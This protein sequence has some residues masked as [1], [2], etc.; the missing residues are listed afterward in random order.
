MNTELVK[1]GK[2][3]TFIGGILGIAWTSF[4]FGK[5]AG[6]TIYEKEKILLHYENTALKKSYDSLQ[7]IINDYSHK[8]DRIIEIC[9]EAEEIVKE[10][11][12][13]P[14]RIK[15]STNVVDNKFIESN[16]K[17]RA[18]KINTSSLF[19]DE[20][21]RFKYNYLGQK[22]RNGYFTTFYKINNNILY[23]SIIP[24]W[25]KSGIKGYN[26][27]VVDW[28]DIVLYKGNSINVQQAKTRLIHTEG[29]H[30]E[31]NLD[32]NATKENGEIHIPVE[33]ISKKGPA[34]NSTPT[35]YISTVKLKYNLD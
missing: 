25:S 10:D 31:F 14:I 3:V 2:I 18:T 8:N 5:E 11:S 27:L 32:T 16:K 33:Y 22:I 24:T 15:D 12:F 9:D 21:V 6:S 20:I 35:K 7:T 17:E 13:T 29:I 23:V 26:R 19:T 30:L 4:S 1:F 34:S 28:S